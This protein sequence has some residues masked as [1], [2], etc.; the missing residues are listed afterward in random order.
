MPTNNP[1]DI[2]EIPD[3]G[4]INASIIDSSNPLVFIKASDISLTGK[5]NPNEINSN[6][7]ILD[8]LE[9]IRGISA[10][11]RTY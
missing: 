1:V 9:V 7:K 8:L 10:V 2:L 3:F 4:K 11:K 5:E 6:Q